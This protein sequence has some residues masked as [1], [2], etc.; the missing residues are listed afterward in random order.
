MKAADDALVIDLGQ[1]FG[2]GVADFVGRE[3]D[4]SEAVDGSRIGKFDAIFVEG[5][6][7]FV[8]AKFLAFRSIE[9]TADGDSFDEQI[10]VVLG[11][12]ERGIVD[13]GGTIQ[14]E[15][16]PIESRGFVGVDLD[17]DSGK[18]A[19]FAELK[20]AEALA[21]E[22]CFAFCFKLEGYDEIDASA[23][24]FRPGRGD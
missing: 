14:D 11:A 10:L 13:E 23:L 12:G 5:V 21:G 2:E 24:R 8:R 6:P 3:E 18:G 20:L 16:V 9:Q 15:T 1:V 19:A 7:D 4:S 17:A 22:G